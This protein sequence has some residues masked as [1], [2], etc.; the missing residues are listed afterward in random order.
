MARK[1]LSLAAIIG[2]GAVVLT[3]CSTSSNSGSSADPTKL[4]YLSAAENTTVQTVLKGLSTNQCTAQNKALPL[5]V[6]TQPQTAIDQKI[7]LLAGQKALP[8][9]MMPNSPAT[10]KTLGKAGSLEN[11]TTKL[12]SLGVSDD[13]T[14]AALSTMQQIFG[15]TQYTL[16]TEFNV[17][18]IWYN[19]KIFADNNITVPT[20]WDGLVAAAAK[21][22]SAGVQPFS[23]DGKDGWPVTRLI[24]NYLFRELGP[25]AMKDIA[26]GKTKLTDADYVKAATAIAGLGSKGYFG[27]SV[28]SIDYDTA[29]NSFVT[30]KSA[31]FYMGT[32]ILSTFNDS[33]KTTIGADN[34]GFMPFPTVSGGKGTIDQ[35]PANVGTPIVFSSKTF[36]AK[37]GDWVKCIAQNY[38]TAALKSSG[39]ISGFKVNA[40][41][42]DLPA[43]TTGVQ[44]TITDTKSTV[45]WFEALFSS[46]GTTVSNQNAAPLLTGQVTPQDFMSLVQAAQAQ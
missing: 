27:S 38:G 14:P 41:V 17:E 12:K 10:T 8:S 30:G 6:T 43:L 5:T 3:A 29:V 35:I 7:Q 4:T 23:A 18:G 9:L 32:W 21:L 46:K 22:D 20:T 31:M 2:V 26:D 37:T 1:V 11:L 13:I 39:V 25:N 44:T 36:G 42:A 15:D 16:P 34:I 28:G 40:P 24:G 45:L 19:K 33:T